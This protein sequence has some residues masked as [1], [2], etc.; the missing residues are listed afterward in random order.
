LFLYTGLLWITLSIRR[1]AFQCVQ[2]EGVGMSSL[3]IT[4]IS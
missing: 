3:P 1:R 4:K 2:N